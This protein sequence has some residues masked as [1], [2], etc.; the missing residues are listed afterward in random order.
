MA[1]RDGCWKRAAQE[2]VYTRERER[3][4]EQYISQCS[5]FPQEDERNEGRQHE[6]ATETYGAKLPRL[7]P[8]ARAGVEAHHENDVDRGPDVKVLEAEVPI[9]QPWFVRKIPFPEPEEIEIA[10][11]ENEGVENLR[12]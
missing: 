10:C 9:P 5:L 4:R 3:K 11:D 6:G 2:R 1:T 7:F 8:F 12:D